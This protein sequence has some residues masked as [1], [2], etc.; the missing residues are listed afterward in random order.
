MARLPEHARVQ[1]DETGFPIDEGHG[2]GFFSRA[3][4]L[5]ETRAVFLDGCGLPDRWADRSC[6]TIGELG[7]GTG[8]NLLATLQLWGNARPAG[9]W[10]HFVSFEAYP[11]RTEDAARTHALW[12]ELSDLSET[13]LA[14]WPACAAGVQ[15]IELTQLRATLTLHIGDA[16]TMLPRA[17]LMADAWFLDGFAPSRNGA[18][19][20]PEVLAAVAD[21]TAP[22]G[23]LATYSSARAVRDGLE[24]A[25][26][27]TERLPGFGGKKHRLVA[28]KADVISPDRTQ[29]APR[30][31]PRSVIIVGGGIGGVAAASLLARRGLAVTMIDPDLCGARKASNNPAALVMPRLDRGDTPQA[32]F[33]RSAWLLA[34]ETLREMDLT[35]FEPSLVTE[36]A[37]TE[38]DAGRIA[39]LSADPVLPA[40]LLTG[41][42]EHLLHKGGGVVRP[43]SLRKALLGQ[44]KVV[45]ASVADLVSTDGQ[46]VCQSADGAEIARA[47]A[48][49]VAAGPGIEALL[50]QRHLPLEGRAGQLSLADLKA[51]ADLDRLPLAGGAY[52]LQFEQWLLYGATFDPWPLDQPPEPVSQNNHKRNLTALSSLSTKLAEAIRPETAWGRTS[53]RV[54][55]SDRM[56]LAGELDGAPGLFVLGA[57]GS[58]GYTTAWL[59]A[60]IVAAKMLGEPLPVDG[61]S[62]ACVC[63]MRFAARAARK[64]A[65]TKR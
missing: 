17:N 49:V 40:T 43:A 64:L 30:P 51:E 21:K 32:R 42:G 1:F 52:A 47:D 23:V 39:D 8:L 34:V 53:V 14:R 55:T 19:W 28:T 46:W 33:H 26:L 2:D 3:D 36:L 45:E 58:R 48:C 15:R 6:F 27:S 41:D 63:P 37:K 20:S 4:G 25:G 60:A 11:M 59:C 5:N 22:G 29:H 10:L 9:G 57:L 18:M 12:P 24:A 44:I 56:P 61:E 7:F 65:G 35:S 16:G 54:A 62:A 13:L 31:Q 50:G 38:R